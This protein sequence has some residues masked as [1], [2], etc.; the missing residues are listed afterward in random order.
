MGNLTEEV[1]NTAPKRHTSELTKRNRTCRASHSI[2][3]KWNYLSYDDDGDG[4]GESDGGVQ[5]SITQQQ[6][7]IKAR[8]L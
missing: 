3:K 8:D 4:E 2:W 1:S 7:L 6:L 5:C